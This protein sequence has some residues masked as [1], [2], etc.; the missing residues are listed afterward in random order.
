[1]QSERYYKD[2]PLWLR[3]LFCWGIQEVRHQVWNGKEMVEPAKNEYHPP[4]TDGRI[5]E[6]HPYRYVLKNGTVQDR[7]ATIYGDEREWRWKWFTWLPWPNK[8]SR[9]ISVEFSDEVGERTGSWKGG[10]I[11]CDYE[12]RHDETM[13]QALRRMEKERKF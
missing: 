8:I 11:G 1:M 2:V 4:Y 12:W 3:L 5:V 9:C 13:L 10:T 6:Y 7:D